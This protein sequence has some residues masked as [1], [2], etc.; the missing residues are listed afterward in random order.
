LATKLLGGDAILGTSPHHHH[1][2]K[3]QGLQQNNNG[4]LTLENLVLFKIQDFRL[5]FLSQCLQLHALSGKNQLVLSLTHYEV[6][7]DVLRV[8]LREANNEQDYLS[9]RMVFFLSGLVGTYLGQGGRGGHSSLRTIKSALRT[10]EAWKNAT[11]YLGVLDECLARDKQHWMHL[12][13]P[14]QEIFCCEVKNEE[15]I[16]LLLSFRLKALAKALLELQAPSTILEE[17]LVHVREKHG[18]AQRKEDLYAPL[19]LRHMLWLV[20]VLVRAWHLPTLADAG[21]SWDTEKSAEVTRPGTD[22]SS[23]RT[24]GSGLGGTEAYLDTLRR[25][26]SLSAMVGTTTPKSSLSN[27]LR[28]ASET[29]LRAAHGASLGFSLHHEIFRIVVDRVVANPRKINLRACVLPPGPAVEG[30]SPGKGIPHPSACLCAR[31]NKPWRVLGGYE[32]QWE[33]IRRYAPVILCESCFRLALHRGKLDQ[34][35]FLQPVGIAALPATQSQRP[36]SIL[37]FVFPVPVPE[38]EEMEPKGKRENGKAGQEGDS[39]RGGKM[40]TTRRAGVRRRVSS[41]GSEGTSMSSPALSVT[42]TA[43]PQVAS[44]SYNAQR[45]GSGRADGELS[46]S[47]R[48]DRNVTDAFPRG[49]ALRGSTERRDSDDSSSGRSFSKTRGPG[50]HGAGASPYHVRSS[51]VSSALS[52]PPQAPGWIDPDHRGSHSRPVRRFEGTRLSSSSAT[53]LSPSLSGHARA[54]RRASGEASVLGGRR[55]EDRGFDLLREVGIEVLKHGRFGCVVPHYRVLFVDREE[56]Y[57]CRREEVGKKKKKAGARRGCLSLSHLLEV[58]LK[59]GARIVS[60]TF[61]ERAFVVEA[62]SDED[63]DVLAAVFTAVMKDNVQDSRQPIVIS[64]RRR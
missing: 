40:V 32:P 61:Q 30:G 62:L 8:I 13:G 7:T 44:T 27:V 16:S 45:N 4:V 64:R 9:I 31:P 49:R 36:E 56:V 11:F 24:G 2:F 47:R 38:V 51:S 58:R 54:N 55:R 3:F 57:W 35:C 41:T 53:G 17:L 42:P 14:L 34:A 18:F 19:D 48:T 6:L 21:D 52:Y 28:W 29:T 63:F 23:A 15:I 50:V 22:S 5:Q 12:Q 37:A 59:K 26:S 1:H 20:D 39:G 33:G 10:H 46:A 60:L 43:S 25:R